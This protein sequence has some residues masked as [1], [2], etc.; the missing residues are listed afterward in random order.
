MKPELP[1]S[2]AIVNVVVGL[3]MPDLTDGLSADPV[4]LGH[5][6]GRPGCGV[7]GC[8]LQRLDHDGLDDLVAHHVIPRSA[9]G[10]TWQRADIRV[11]GQVG[12]YKPSCDASGAR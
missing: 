4:P 5:R 9:S 1:G 12:P 2:R 7:L 8:G 6:P 10:P 3:G 11:T